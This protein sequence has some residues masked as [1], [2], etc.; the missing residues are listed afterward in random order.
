[1]EDREE[2]LVDQSE[3]Q[4][5]LTAAAPGRFTKTCGSNLQQEQACPGL[6]STMVI[7][8]SAAGLWSSAPYS[9]AESQPLGRSPKERNALKAAARGARQTVRGS[10]GR[11]ACRPQRRRT[12]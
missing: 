12:P 1:M 3:R 7:A 6:R 4:P 8:T 11:V 10:P 5:T 9:P 2:M